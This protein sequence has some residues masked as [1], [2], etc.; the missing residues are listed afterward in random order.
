MTEAELFKLKDA[1]MS[2]NN[3]KYK[4]KPPAIPAAYSIQFKR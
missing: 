3:S 4:P 1:G 2:G